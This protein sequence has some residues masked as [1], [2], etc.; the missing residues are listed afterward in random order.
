M[1]VLLTAA[2]IAALVALASV[3]VFVLVPRRG[4]RCTNRNFYTEDLSVT[5]PLRTARRRVASST[6]SSAR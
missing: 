1:S 2:A 6:R 5:G 4:T 3:I